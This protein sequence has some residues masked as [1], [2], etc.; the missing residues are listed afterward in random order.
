MAYFY[1]DDNIFYNAFYNDINVN[2]NKN[3]T[4]S[5]YLSYQVIPLSNDNSLI[6]YYTLNTIYSNIYLLN[7]ATN[8]YDATISGIISGV[9]IDNINY[10]ISNGSINFSTTNIGYIQFPN[11]IISSYTGITV[12]IWVKLSINN[13]YARIFD[14]HYI[15]N[16]VFHH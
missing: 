16:I 1:I 7:N 2:S 8:K 5:S 15:Q 10:R 11:L 12:T 14:F 13:I 4:I 6:Y 9:T 3:I